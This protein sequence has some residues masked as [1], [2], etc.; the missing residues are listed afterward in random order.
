MIVETLEESLLKYKV[1]SVPP[2]N[3]PND[4]QANPALWN[5]TWVSWQDDDP[6]EF[7]FKEVDK[8]PIADPIDKIPGSV[9][10]IIAVLLALAVLGIFILIGLRCSKEFNALK[11][12]Q[13]QSAYQSSK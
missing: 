11:K 2:S 6:L 7:S 1:T 9:V 8:N 13:Q 4:P 10:A 3:V 12:K 5:G